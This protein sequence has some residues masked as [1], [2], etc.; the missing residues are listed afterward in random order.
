MSTPVPLRDDMRAF[1]ELMDKLSAAAEEFQ[2]LGNQFPPQLR[3]QTGFVYIQDAFFCMQLAIDFYRDANRALQAE[4]WF[5]ATI[6]AGSALESILLAK[7][8]MQKEDVMRLPKWL[9][10][11]KSHRDDFAKFVRSLDL[12]KLLEIAKE[13]AWLNTE[14]LPRVFIEAISP[15]LDESSKAE[16]MQTVG[17][18]PDFGQTCANRFREYRNML[19]PAV[20]LRE[21]FKPTKESCTVATFL[22]LIAFSSLAQ[23]TR[24]AK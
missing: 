1:E 18:E 24:M 21:G 4:A 19:H 20:C 3:L 17:N 13:L 10:L 15:Y 11:K 7:C 9:Q 22:F 2:A 14:G 6:A 12:G 16:L 23:A 5:S 8:L